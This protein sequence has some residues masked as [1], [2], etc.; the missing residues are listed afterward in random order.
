[1]SRLINY[2]R[3]SDMGERDED[4]ASTQTIETQRE[5]SAAIVK[6]TAGARI[7]DE[8]K[9]LNASGGKTW[10]EPKLAEAIARVD[11]GEADG[12]V[13]Y[14]L[15]RFGRHLKALEVIERWAEEGKTFLSASDKFDVTTPSGRMCLRMMMIVARFYWEQ[16]RDRFAEAQRKAFARGAHIGRTPLGYL[17]IDDED[18]P[19]VG[20]LVK[21]PVYG[22]IVSQAF[23]IA[24]EEGLRATGEYLAEHV[25]HRRWSTDDVRG[26]LKLRSY[27]GEV[28]L[29]G[30]RKHGHDELTDLETYAAAQIDPHFR[31]ANSDYPL[32]GIAT[33]GR[34]QEPMTGGLQSFPDRE[35]TYRRM[36]C[37]KCHRCSIA[38]EGLE[39][40]ARELLRSALGSQPFRARFSVD[41][42]D[43]ARDVL[44]AAEAELQRFAADR[45]FREIVGDAAWRAGARERRAALNEAQARFEAVA[46]SSRRSQRLPAPEQ[47]DD[48]KHFALA[49]SLVFDAIVIA[50]GR[51]TVANRV[52]DLRFV[53]DDPAGTEL[54]A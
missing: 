8:V 28:S 6:L 41:T 26:L 39:D 52:V 2:I 47:L 12:I 31:R 50:P 19:K 32:S 42:L 27:L 40:W 36:R 38:A 34:C 54:A 1:V 29:G 4:S 15:D 45:E 25:P 3:V 43:K 7:I 24:A 14:A 53:V 37:T 11:A 10:P 33:C 16:Q 17:R 35:Q 13:V 49:L 23:R 20:C 48:P 30:E 18:N 46:S 9:A 5:G 21:D 22:P 51:G 44:T